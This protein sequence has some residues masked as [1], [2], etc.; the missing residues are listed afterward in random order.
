MDLKTN[1]IPLL[2]IKKIMKVEE[3]VNNIAVEAP[4][5]MNII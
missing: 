4:A 5:I 2:R 1:R 3:G